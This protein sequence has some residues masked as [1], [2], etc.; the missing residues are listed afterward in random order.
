MHRALTSLTRTASRV[1]LAHPAGALAA[2]AQSAAAAR[3]CAAAAAPSVAAA[4]AAACRSL[5][6][7]RP[8]RA[9]APTQ[10]PPPPPEDDLEDLFGEE[11]DIA[12]T[13]KPASGSASSSAASSSSS[14]TLSSLLKSTRAAIASSPA[15]ST[16]SLD[17]ASSAGLVLLDPS[18][19]PRLEGR[20]FAML[21]FAT[22]DVATK[23]EVARAQAKEQLMATGSTEEQAGAEVANSPRV[24]VLE[25]TLSRLQS[26]CR[27]LF[28]PEN[29][30]GFD[31][32]RVADLLDYA[33][34]MPGVMHLV[35]PDALDP[36]KLM[37]FDQNTSRKNRHQFC[38]FCKPST[39]TL[40]RNTLVYTNVNLLTQFLNKR[41]M[42]MQRQESRLCM[43]HQRALARTIKRARSIGLLSP[44]SNWRVPADFVFGTSGSK[45]S[46]KQAAEVA[47]GGAGRNPFAKRPDLP[48]NLDMDASAAGAAGAGSNFDL[49]A[50][51]NLSSFGADANA[52]MAAGGPPGAAGTVVS[53]S[54]EDDDD[55]MDTAR[56]PTRR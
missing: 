48:S 12:A 27:R 30:A 35:Q 44:M 33:E 45:F 23:L 54:I 19:P 37:S 5:H 25:E 34:S 15:G 9:A 7:A 40:E 14:S 18:N 42:I 26:L 16:P 51:D 13:T 36:M 41:G 6:T 4:S 39:A 2:A 38:L 52:T 11:L 31:D 17:N 46:A 20:H 3:S 49:S 32:K 1:H 56:R 22:T 8:R 21:K 24:K 53:P 50:F 47:A 28:P 29:S 55:F 10:P 43:K